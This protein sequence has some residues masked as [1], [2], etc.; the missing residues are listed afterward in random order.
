MPMLSFYRPPKILPIR[1]ARAPALAPTKEGRAR[2][3]LARPS[4]ESKRAEPYFFK[5]YLSM[6]DVNA[7]RL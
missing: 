3:Y 4:E 6:T 5:M 1:K 2:M 7:L